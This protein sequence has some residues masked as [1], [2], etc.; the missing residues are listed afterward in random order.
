MLKKHAEL[1][2]EEVNCSFYH[3]ESAEGTANIDTNAAA[4][5]MLLEEVVLPFEIDRD[6]NYQAINV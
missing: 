1:A 4:R 5:S 3:A 6:P 2:Q